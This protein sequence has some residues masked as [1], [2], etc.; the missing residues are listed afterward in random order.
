M[1]VTDEGHINSR[2]WKITR[3]SRF[4]I[5]RSRSSSWNLSNTPLVLLNVTVPPKVSFGVSRHLVLGYGDGLLN[6][7]AMFDESVCPF[8]GGEIGAGRI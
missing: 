5:R 6:P 8:L 1:C 4:R 7:Q 3:R 2:V